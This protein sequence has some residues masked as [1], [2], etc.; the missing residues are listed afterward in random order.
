M[1]MARN[2]WLLVAL[3]LAVASAT[4]ACNGFSEIEFRQIDFSRIEGP[5]ADA[6]DPLSP[7]F[8]G[9]GVYPVGR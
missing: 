5:D 8:V 6:P 1:E 9:G 3:L 4:A 2:R 7:S